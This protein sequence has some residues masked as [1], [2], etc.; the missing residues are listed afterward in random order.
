MKS[1][2]YDKTKKQGAS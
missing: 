1:Q 2:K